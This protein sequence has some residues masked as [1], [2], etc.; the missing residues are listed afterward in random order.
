LLALLA[1]FTLWGV[2]LLSLLPGGWLILFISFPQILLISL[3]RI[4]LLILLGAPRLLA[5]SML[6]TAL[7][8][9]TLLMIITHDLSSS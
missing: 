8:V 1:W 4:C 9:G 2:G 5:V 7:R 3:L 6:L